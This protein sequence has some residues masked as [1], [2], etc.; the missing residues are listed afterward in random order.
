VRK[1]IDDE[2]TLAAHESLLG[3]CGQ[4]VGVGMRFCHC[5]LRRLQLLA[6]DFWDVLHL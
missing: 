4:K 5:R 1:V 6:H 3:E 2:L